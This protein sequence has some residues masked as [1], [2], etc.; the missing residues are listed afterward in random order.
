ML[1]ESA[2]NSQA[3]ARD[4]DGASHG[5]P[6]G[7]RGLR[8]IEPGLLVLNKPRGITSR[9][10]VDRVVRLVGRRT[11]VGHAGTL[12]PLASGVLVVLVGAATRL[13]EEVQ[14]LTKTYRTVVRLGAR[15][16]TLDAD[17]RIEQVPDPRRPE[18][19]EIIRAVAPLVGEV[20][21]VPPGFSALKVGGRRAYDLARAGQTVELAPRRVRID[22]IDVVRYEWPELELEIDCGAGTYIRSIARDVG[23]ALGCGGLVDVL[24]RTG[25]GPFRIEDAVDPSRL[26]AES[27]PGLMRPPAEAVSGLPRRVL[28]TDELVALASG[29]RLAARDAAEAGSRVALID[30]D[31]RLVALGEVE[32]SGGWIQPRKVLLAADARP[33]AGRA[34]EPS[35]GPNSGPAIGVEERPQVS[36]SLPSAGPG[37]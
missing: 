35:D 2:G 30:P 24:V 17:G 31:G 36:V 27:L 33:A 18:S 29:R 16:D 34:G 9:S 23:E 14:R 15:S 21:Q 13:V 22:R 5:K 28:E 8:P 11:R 19:A 37:E 32:G 20:E 4:G 25:I 1:F 26:T 10:A 12:D 7:G 3:Q 6:G